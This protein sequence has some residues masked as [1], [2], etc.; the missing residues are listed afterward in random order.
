MNHGRYGT[1]NAGLRN[2]DSSA[3]LTIGVLNMGVTA[4]NRAWGPRIAD[5]RER[6]NTASDG[7]SSSLRINVVFQIPGDLLQPDF[8]GMRTG[9]FRS[10]DNLLLVQVALPEAPPNDADFLV[11]LMEA[12]PELVSK[13]AARR[14][15]EADLAPLETIIGRLR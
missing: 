6:V 14:R 11:G 2:F 13:W 5:L 3:P 15:L 4:H 9:S 10:S 7:I 1:V 12:V 8:E